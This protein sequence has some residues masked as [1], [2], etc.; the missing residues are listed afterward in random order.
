M[1]S[2]HPELDAYYDGEVSPQQRRA[3]AEHVHSCA[4]CQQELAERR[5]L[6]ALLRTVPAPAPRLSVAQVRRRLPERALRA[7]QGLVFAPLALAFLS[8]SVLTALVRLAD[9][10]LSF[11]PFTFHGQPWLLS[12]LRPLL[13]LPFLQAIGQ[14]LSLRGWIGWD[15]W[16]WLGF[17]LLWAAM[18]AGLLV[19]EWAW[20]RHQTQFA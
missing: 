13:E 14:V 9:G 3:I 18:S 16:A 6:S 8:W 19:L 5:R 11:L 1:N 4:V 7:K 15:E 20:T 12:W 17:S 10:V 2:S